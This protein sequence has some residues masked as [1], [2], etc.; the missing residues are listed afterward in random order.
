MAKKEDIY[1]DV[2]PSRGG[3]VS[4]AWTSCGISQIDGEFARRIRNINRP[5]VKLIK[6]ERKP[7]YFDGTYR[8]DFW[9]EYTE[10]PLDQDFYSYDKV[11]FIHDDES[12]LFKQ[13]EDTRTDRA[14]ENGIQ[15]QQF[16]LLHPIYIYTH[17]TYS[18][19]HQ[20]E[21]PKALAKEIKSH[22]SLHP[23]IKANLLGNLKSYLE[24]NY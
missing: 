18:A 13:L 11:S 19:K 3:Y 12:Q 2:A 7:H 20:G 14:K 16:E 22:K 15:Y 4:S 5:V 8:S 21:D 6:V 1:Y 24:N 10:L 23:K 17:P 9:D